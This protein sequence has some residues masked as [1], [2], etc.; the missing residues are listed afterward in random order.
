MHV[1]QILYLLLF[2]ST[3]YSCS[4]NQIQIKQ[5]SSFKPVYIYNKTPF[6][7][8]AYIRGSI[9]QSA[10]HHSNREGNT[11]TIPAT[12]ARTV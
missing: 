10:R 3:M 1:K 12:Q 9:Q 4:E 5:G 8:K 11:V 2:T 6:C 7:I